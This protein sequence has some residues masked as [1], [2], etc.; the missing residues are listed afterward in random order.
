MHKKL[1]TAVL[2]LALALGV[3]FASAQSDLGDVDPTGQTI[4]YWHEWN[5]AQS[6]AINQIIE[7]FNSTNAYGITVTTVAQG[8]TGNM[9]GAMST[10][11]TGGGLPNLVGGFSNNAQSWYL[12]DVS[13][14]LDPY[15]NDETWGFTED[16]MADINF[17]LIDRF[18]RV[19][20]EPFG[21]QLLAWPIG[22]S[23][24]VMSVNLG[25]LAE[26]GFDGPPTSLEQFREVACAA[27]EFTNAS[28]DDVLGF[29]IRLSFDDTVSFIIN[30][31]GTI[32][33]DEN[34]EF[35]FNN[36]ATIA[37]M[38]FFQELINDGCAYVPETNF[39]NTADFAYSRNPMA[40]GSTAGVPFILNDSRAANEAGDT[41]VADW[42]NTTP[43]WTEGNRNLTIFFRSIVP[44]TSTPEAQLAT[45][46]FIKHMA[47][48]ESQ[49]IWTE[50]TQY[51]PYTTSGLEGLSEEF[52][53][54]NPQ[55][56]DIRALLLDESIIQ[57][58]A[59]Q[60]LGVRES[61]APFES[62]LANILT[63]GQ[64]V[65]TAVAAAEDE[66]N[67]LF[68]DYQSVLDD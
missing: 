4:V 3:G 65:A 59:P 49:V 33:D 64:D 62:M 14:A 37:V 43:P 55:F 41:G 44:L 35:T 45:W 53:G 16:E 12:D 15:I 68:S 2:L 61:I 9:L 38:T 31:G 11:I 39:S 52:L 19:H 8:T 10:A 40:V 26:L 29:P 48:T 5:E 6:V 67:A 23:A 21:G 46:L 36:D 42:V 17:E 47:S 50:T 7:N 51:F 32:F 24:N 56:D 18:N 63:G 25:M 1:I 20:S 28:G 57:F 58:G 60:Y 34:L 27:S 22:M 13:F 66:V 30:Q 54:N